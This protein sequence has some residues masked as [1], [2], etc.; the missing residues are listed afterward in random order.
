MVS[1]SPKA[2]DKIT[3]IVSDL[4]GTL[5]KVDLLD[6]LAESV[7]NGKESQDIRALYQE[8]KEDGIGSLISRVSLLKGISLDT[9]SLVLDEKWLRAGASIFSQYIYLR[10]RYRILAT[11]N[12]STIANFFGH[13]LGCDKVL[14]TQLDIIDNKIV[15]LARNNVYKTVDHLAN[16]LESQE[17]S[18]E[19]CIYIG[20]GVSDI[21]FFNYCKLSIAF[22]ASPEVSKYASASGHGDLKNLCSVIGRILDDN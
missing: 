15:S 1:N 2:R 9:V 10:F 5:T 4:D 13:I 19:N 16:Y 14:S 6:L 11:G 12:I 22:N 20:D 18:P 17:I 8:S 21:P 3:T 7:G